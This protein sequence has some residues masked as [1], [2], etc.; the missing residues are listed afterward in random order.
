MLHIVLPLSLLS[1]N[2]GN[3]RKTPLGARGTIIFDEMADAPARGWTLRLR[4]ANIGGNGMLQLPK[5]GSTTIGELQDLVAENAQQGA[6]GLVIKAGFPPKEL[7]SDSGPDATISALGVADAETLIVDWPAGDGARDGGHKPASSTAGAKR[8]APAKEQERDQGA[9]GG[10]ATT[11]TKSGRKTTCTSEKMAATDKE[12]RER[13]AFALGKGSAKGS[14]P[15]K[16]DRAAAIEAAAKTKKFKHAGPGH[17]LTGGAVTPA[18]P[19]APSAA[20]DSAAASAAPAGSAAAASGRGRARGGGLISGLQ[21]TGI[22]SLGSE[23][24]G[25]QEGQSDLSADLV[26]AFEPGR[27]RNPMRVALKEARKKQALQPKPQNLN[28]KT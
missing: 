6:D 1:Q 3:V 14:S 22:Q 9:Q 8:K 26:A 5:A 13:E 23:A 24:S 10:K 28:P 7:S 16:A 2:A 15:A 11:T 18:A 27:S 20:G 4:G 19:A 12:L 17:S 21:A 25:A